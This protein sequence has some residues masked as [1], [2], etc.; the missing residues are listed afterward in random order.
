M[1]RAADL[2]EAARGAIGTGDAASLARAIDENLEV[3]RSIY[4][5]PAWQV[6]MADAARACGA[7][8]NFAGSGGAIVGTYETEAA[9]DR[10]RHELAA[11][12]CRTIKPSIEADRSS[13]LL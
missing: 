6:Q 12:G 7:S 11:S 10:L 1:R 5:L 4:R 2:A 8:A 13:S 9:F 3:R